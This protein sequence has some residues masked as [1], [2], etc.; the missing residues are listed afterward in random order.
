[1]A[2]AQK[3]D[4]EEQESNSVRASKVT[5]PVSHSTTPTPPPNPKPVISKTNTA[6]QPE[7]KPNPL[8]GTDAKE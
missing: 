6:Q 8:K 7:I 3:L 4:R 5:S 1:M 2:I